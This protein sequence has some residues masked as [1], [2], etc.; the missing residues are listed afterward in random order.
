SGQ[1]QIWVQSFPTGAGKFQVSAGGGAQPRWRRDGKEIFY[2]GGDGK[3]MA[4]EVKTNPQF[5]VI[6]TPKAV[7]DSYITVTSF[8]TVSYDV[9]ADGKRFLAASR[10]DEEAVSAQITVVLNWQAGLKR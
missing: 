6:G 2:L 1:Y 4:V 3:L 9:G 10:S 5:Q 8:W 7:F